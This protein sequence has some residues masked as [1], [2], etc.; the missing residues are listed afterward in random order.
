MEEITR[1]LQGKEDFQSIM[2]GLDAGF[3]E[4]LIAGVSGIG[5]SLTISTVYRA[6]KKKMLVVTHQLVHAQQLYDDLSELVED[7]DV[8]LYPVN[9]HIATEMVV[10]S[11]EL[12]AERIRSLV[13]WL[14][15]PAGILI[16]PVAG[17]KRVVPP[18]HYWKDYCIPIELGEIIDLESTTEALFHMGYDRVDMVTAPAEFS[19]R[20]GIIDVYPVTENHP[21][22]IELFGDEVDSIRHFDANTQRSLKNIEKTTIV[23]SKE[24]LVTKEDQIRAANRLEKA[25][26]Q[27]LKKMA[28]TEAKLR[29]KDNIEA[30]IANLQEA[31]FFQEMYKYSK[32]FYEEANSL[33][34]YL[35][36]DSLLI[37]DDFNRIQEAA[38]T[39]DQEEADIIEVLLE[40]RLLLPESRFTFDWTEIKDHFHQQRLYLSIFLRH[41]SG[42]QPDNIVNLS[43]RPMQEFHGQMHLFQNEVNRWKKA[44][45]SIIVVAENEERAERVQSILQDYEMEFVIQDTLTLPALTPTIVVGGLTKGIELPLHRLALITEQELF[46]K[47]QR[48]KRSAQTTL[49]NAERIKNYQELKV[50]DY[51]VHRNHGIG[52]YV[53]IETLEVGGI[54]KDYLLI[55]YAGDDRLYVPIDQIELVQK[56]V[57]SEGKEPRMYKLGGAEWQKVKRRVQSSVENI[58][59]ELIKLYATRQAQ[60]GYAFEPDSPLQEE[61]EMSFPYDETE[62]QL[63]CIEEIKRDMESERPMDRLLCG[64]VG[65]GKTEVALRAI[66]KAVSEGKQAAFLVPT[67]ILAQQH[68]QTMQ[69]RFQDYPLEIGLLSRF[70][71]AK[72]QRET[73]EGLKNGTVD[74]VVGTHRLLSKDIAFKDLGLLVVDE[75]QRFGVKH[76][77]KIKQMKTNVDVLTL[78]ATPIPRTL[79]MSMLGIRD[80]SVI[81]TPPENRFPVQTYVME[82]NRAFVKEAIERELA[83]DGQ[84][85][86]LY[87]RVETIEK[88]AR[89]I[90]ELVPEARIQIA[91][92]RM[93]EAELE[94]VML[95]FLEGE[96]DVL[97]STTII[98][99]GVDI[100]NVNTLIVLD[101]DHMGLSQLYQLRGRVGRSNRI[102]YAYFTYRKGKVLTEESEKRLQAIKEFTELGSGFKIA[103]RDLSIR[104]A[105]NLLG[106]EQHGFIDSV[107]F[108]LYSQMLKEAID[109]RKEQKPIESVRPFNPELQLQVDAYIP[110]SYIEDEKQKF[111]VY[112]RFQQFDSYDSMRDF[113]DELID[114]FGDYP[115][116]VARLFAVSAL[117]MV[118]KKERVEEIVEE[119]QSIRLT[120]EEERSL[121]IDGAKLFQLAN[122]FGR[123]VQLGTAGNQLKVTFRWKKE[124]QEERYEIVRQFIERLSEVNLDEKKPTK[125]EVQTAQD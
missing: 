12:R 17:L 45:Y 92:G 49:S 20:G 111:E 65:Y 96:S 63:R 28:S 73:I 116:E 115:E 55:Q 66:F 125:E 46:K 47:K 95:S 110:S 15:H 72:Q 8:Y 27:A 29:L 57:G 48:R 121:A 93:K 13:A 109:A 82:Y 76:K 120:L 91:H 50:G 2:D 39:L 5:R 74:I 97:V 23:P 32:L 105:G 53:G 69:E 124:S 25:L 98:E 38:T 19:I 24:L 102:A 78:T 62:D 94:D 34:D 70:R 3:Q 99:T 35:P 52:K 88:V 33:L 68:Y 100:P 112:K 75:E 51:V 80:L 79:H 22:R 56:Y 107:G 54:H 6:R 10:S 1:F 85:F 7:S 58:A 114:R 9:E 61:F 44:S 83:R 106:A 21:I 40:E 67:T 71:T 42:T 43:S 87:N 30:D 18:Q 4:Q 77:E 90:D 16:V 26:A 117:K 108:D 14:H 101:A 59:D 89:E 64:D 11:P 123:R 81:E 119:Q 104:G 36:D 86:V 118:A 103:M 113:Q 37:F 31:E 41:I 84:V 60:K 122:E